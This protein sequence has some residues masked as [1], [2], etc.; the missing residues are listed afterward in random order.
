MNV[1]PNGFDLRLFKPNENSSKNLL[2]TLTLAED[3]VLIGHVA[4]WDGQKDHA[5]LI[6]AAKMVIERY[7]NA[8][9]ILCGQNID[10]KNDILCSY[11][12]KA[13]VEK[14]I[15]LMGRRDDIPRIM[16]Q[17][18]LLVSS[19]KAGEGFPNVL[20]E[21]MACEVPCVTT[22]VGD[23]AYIVGDTGFVVPPENPQALADA[24]IRYFS[25]SFEERKQLGRKARKRVE[26]YFALDLVVEKYE[27][28]YQSLL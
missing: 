7:P 11:I 5:N 14:N 26:T 15:H 6:K 25:L 20:G 28:I 9:F 2:E 8:H 19:S 3:A 23:S 10:H 16:P 18:D 24:M 27:S 4:R 1:I 12:K 13:G 17:F 21:A 22:D